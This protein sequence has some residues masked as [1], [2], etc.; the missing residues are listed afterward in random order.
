MRT[1]NKAGAF[2]FYLAGRILLERLPDARTSLNLKSAA[3]LPIGDPAGM[4]EVAELS[5]WLNS[6]AEKIAA[7]FDKRNG[8]E[9]F[10]ERMAKEWPWEA[11]N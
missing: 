10:A 11:P 2:D 8:T 6:E 1:L 7:A 4:V 5:A 9:R 3:K